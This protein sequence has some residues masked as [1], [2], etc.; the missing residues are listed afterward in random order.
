MTREMKSSRVHRES[1]SVICAQRSTAAAVGAAATTCGASG[2]GATSAV[3][4]G[5]AGSAIFGVPAATDGLRSG[6]TGNGLISTGD[7]APAS[8]ASAAGDDRSLD[9]SAAGTSVD[10]GA[11]G[12]VASGGNVD[13]TLEARS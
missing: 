6:F 7:D 3:T 10:R 11:R 8:A 5:A 4:G 12:G 1:S 9:G 13:M 2:A